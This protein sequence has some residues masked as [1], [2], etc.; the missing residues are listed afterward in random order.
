[1]NSVC[2]LLTDHE[3]INESIIIHSYKNLSESKLKKIYFIG[4]KLKFPKIYKKF[5]KQKK[6]EFINIKLR[7]GQFLKYLKSVTNEAIKLCKNNK[8]TIILNMPLNKK[9]FLKNNYPG[10]TE[11]FSYHLDKKKNENML[12]YNEKNF[13]VCPLTTHIELKKVENNINEKKLKNCINNIVN[14]YKKLNKKIQ[15][16]ILGL[17]PH[18]STD[19]NKNTKDKILISKVINVMRKKNINISG[20]ISADTAFV[21]N[22]K[23][24]VFVGMYHDQVLI[25][26]KTINKFDGINITI[27]KKILRLSPDHGTAKNLRRRKKNINNE[28]FLRCIDFCSKKLNV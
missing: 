11:F 7:T 26:F 5:I 16:V 12:L 28:S 23:N 8:N 20:P 27:G 19:M 9:K 18:A 3:S 6:F 14:F 25:P 17:N 15:I 24:K 4:S 2:I 22:Y 21:E 1:M 13:S 10:F